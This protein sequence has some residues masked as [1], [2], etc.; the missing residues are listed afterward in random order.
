MKACCD[1]SISGAR[2]AR[3]CE[4]MHP[5]SQSPDPASGPRA[6]QAPRHP[7]GDGPWRAGGAWTHRTAQLSPDAGGEPGDTTHTNH[8]VM[9][10]GGTPWESKPG[11][12]GPTDD[13]ALGTLA[14]SGPIWA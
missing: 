3:R 14:A 7:C 4:D 13:G 12:L 5:S 6:H 11:S 9:S 10:R 2:R 8:R 1:D